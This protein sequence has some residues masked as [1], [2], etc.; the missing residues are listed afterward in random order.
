MGPFDITVTF[1]RMTDMMGQKVLFDQANVSMSPQHFKNFCLAANET[2]KAYERVFGELTLAEAD[3]GPPASADLIE[4]MLL[5]AREN[6]AASR[7]VQLAAMEKEATPPSS[8]EKKPPGKRSRGAR[9][10]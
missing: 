7:S 10:P 9:K 6:A 5:A 8:T 4:K 3:I 1:S 2:L